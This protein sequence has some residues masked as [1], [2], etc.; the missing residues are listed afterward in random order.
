MTYCL[1]RSGDPFTREVHPLGSS[2]A[3]EITTGH[4]DHDA[5]CQL[6]PNSTGTSI[7]V[8]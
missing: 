1:A 2:S 4:K 3:S 6:I 8:R 7:G 5:V